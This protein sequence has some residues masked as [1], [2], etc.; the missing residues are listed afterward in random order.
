MSRSGEDRY[1][2]AARAGNLSVADAT[3]VAFV[4]GAG[5]R[6][7]TCAAATGPAP[8]TESAHRGHS[9]PNTPAVSNP[10]INPSITFLDVTAHGWWR[11]I[12]LVISA[13]A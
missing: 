1:D 13:P 11:Q 2:T 4:E 6:R 9:H 8:A 10:K 12:A 5:R 7:R 3:F